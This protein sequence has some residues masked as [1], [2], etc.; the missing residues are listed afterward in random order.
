MSGAFPIAFGRYQ[1]VERLAVGGMAELY[2]A[3]ITGDHG[4]AKTVVIKRILPHLAGD[5]HFTQMFIAE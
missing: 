2:L 1:L 3:E 4:F 5:P